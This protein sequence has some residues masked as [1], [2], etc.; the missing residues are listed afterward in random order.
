MSQALQ[1]FMIY[2]GIFVVGLF[3]GFCIAPTHSKEIDTLNAT[4]DFLKEQVRLVKR[5]SEHWED[6]CRAL[7]ANSR[8]VRFA[9]WCVERLS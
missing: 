9:A 1:L 4:V 5:D 3:V 6:R 2:F 8:M 7:H